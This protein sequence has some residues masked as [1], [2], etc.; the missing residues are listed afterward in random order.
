METIL[1]PHRDLIAAETAEPLQSGEAAADLRITRE[2][3]EQD[4]TVTNPLGAA[5]GVLVGITLGA[6][7]WATTLVTL[8]ILYSAR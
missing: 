8:A 2:S 6:G 3:A 5:R 4:A 7:F 1:L